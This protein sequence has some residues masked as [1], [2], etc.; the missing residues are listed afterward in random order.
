MK[1]VPSRRFDGGRL[2]RIREHR[3]RRRLSLEQPGWRVARV[4]PGPCRDLRPRLLKPIRRPHRFPSH[5]CRYRLRRR[6]HSRCRRYC[7]CHFRYCRCRRRFRCHC[8]QNRRCRFHRRFH[9]CFRRRHCHCLPGPR[10]STARRAACHP[11]RPPPSRA[12]RL[13][14]SL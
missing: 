2:S 6:Y 14:Q 9:H 1:S 5:R 12:A 7:R 10:R 11:H 3:P 4:S 8:R 13:Q